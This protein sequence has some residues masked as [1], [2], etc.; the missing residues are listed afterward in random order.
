MKAVVDTNVL[1][2]GN[3]KHFPAALCRGHSVVTPAN[4]ISILS[5]GYREKQKTPSSDSTTKRTKFTKDTKSGV[6]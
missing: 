3:L 5:D 2:T 4:F 1:V 6:R